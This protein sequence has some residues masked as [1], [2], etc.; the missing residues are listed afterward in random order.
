M[1]GS[2][3]IKTVLVADIGG[4]HS[5]FA[6]FELDEASSDLEMG[7]RLVRKVRFSTKERT[8]S[9][10]MM[11]T[12]VTSAGDDGGYVT[13]FSPVPARVDA[14]VFAIPGPTAVADPSIPA[15][16]NDVR[17]CPNIVWPMEAAVI[18]SGLGGAPVRLV[19]D[20]VANGFACA[21]L[22]R[23]IDAVPVLEGEAQQGFPYAV[24]GAGTGLGQ[25]L[26]LPGDPPTLIGSE[27]GHVL[28]PFVGEEEL[29]LARFMAEKTGT[30]FLDG[31]MALGGPA[32]SYIYA[33]Y[34]GLTAHPHEAAPLAA[35]N[36]QVLAMAAR[37]Y[38][39]AVCHYA[40]LTLA[41][42]GVYITGGLASNLPQIL[43]HPA[44]EAELKG[45][46][47]FPHLLERLPVYHVRNNDTGLW[48]AAACAAYM[49]R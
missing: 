29:A 48:G 42:G 17:Y 35:K 43:T 16:E 36:E 37:L 1:V 18:S 25:C 7:L 45:N 19:N 10:D 6:L 9:A 21:L 49:A 40:M 39:R 22:P 34:T 46:R 27:G 8:S 24:M 5:R 28:F 11:R 15:P 3:S 31:D 38:G 32:L 41:L 4:T 26:V 47:A 2:G 20:F 13:P 33:F 44:F 14:A 12:L 30:P 23:L